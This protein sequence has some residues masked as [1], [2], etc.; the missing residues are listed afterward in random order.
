VGIESLMTNQRLREDLKD[1]LTRVLRKVKK[2]NYVPRGWWPT[3]DTSLEKLG[4]RERPKPVHFL[5]Y[6]PYVQIRFDPGLIESDG[7][8]PLDDGDRSGSIKH[9][10]IERIRKWVRRFGFSKYFNPYRPYEFYGAAPIRKDIIDT[11]K[12]SGLQYM[13]TKSGFNLPPEVKYVDKDFIALNYTAGQWD[14]WTPFETVNDVSDLKSAEKR[15]LRRNKPGWLVSTVDS[16]LWTFS[17]EFW[18]HGSRL[19]EVAEFCAAGGVSKQ[20]IN[21]KPYTISRYARIIAEEKL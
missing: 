11:V 15:L 13:F 20:L 3:M 12:S 18:K 9:N 14:G 19:Y 21:V 4:W 7:R 1:G 16:C 8:T 17:G 10:S 5:R 6:P 2:E